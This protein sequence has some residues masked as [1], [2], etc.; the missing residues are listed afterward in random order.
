MELKL[1]LRKAAGLGRG[2]ADVVVRVQSEREQVNA[3]RN[4]FLVDN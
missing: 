2:V 1:A 3:P 4:H